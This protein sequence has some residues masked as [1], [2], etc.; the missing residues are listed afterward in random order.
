MD[1][2]DLNLTIVLARVW[3]KGGGLGS[4]TPLIKVCL[5]K[6]KVQGVLR[7][8]YMKYVFFSWDF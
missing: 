3:I 6:Q 7:E 2:Y 8:L 1:Y 5:S 4:L